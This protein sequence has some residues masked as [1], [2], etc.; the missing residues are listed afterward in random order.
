MKFAMEDQTLVTLGN[1][2]Q[3]E[4]D[5]LGELVKQLFDAAE[6]LSSTFNGPAKASFN[7]FKSKTDEISNALNSA[8]VGIVT[9]ISG[10]NKAFVA[11]A[12]DGAA[13]HEAATGS[14]DFSSE[15]FLTRIRPQA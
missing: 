11:A 13:T 1:K 12:D 6:P 10:Q 5:D 14:T 2:S 7:N 9:S 3:T 8:L 15:S 4:S